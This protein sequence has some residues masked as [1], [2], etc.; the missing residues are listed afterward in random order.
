MAR[1]VAS[2][3]QKELDRAT[4]EAEEEELNDLKDHVLNNLRE[5]I[6]C[7]SSA[8][9]GLDKADSDNLGI[10]EHDQDERARVEKALVALVQAWTSLS[11]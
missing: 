3:Q 4:A 8:T 2:Q 7:V 9:R 10:W 1:L 6:G 5:A 11:E